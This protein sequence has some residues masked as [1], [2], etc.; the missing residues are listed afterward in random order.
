MDRMRSAQVDTLYRNVTISVFVSAFAAVVLGVSLAVLGSAPIERCVAWSAFICACATL[1][2]G[3]GWLRGR[4]EAAGEAWRLWGRAFAV[5]ALAEGV[6]WG[7][8][9]IG[10]AA[11]DRYDF[12]LIAMLCSYAMAGGVVSVFSSHALSFWCFFL[13]CTVPFAADSLMHGGGE[14]LVGGCLATVYVFGMGAIG[15]R[16][17]AEYNYGLRLRFDIDALARELRHQK[18]LAEEAN[19][20][21]S[22][23]LA[24][25]SHDLRQ[26]VHA[27]GLSVGALKA[28]SMPAAASELVDHIEQSVEALDGLFTALL[29]VSRLDAGVIT[30]EPRAFA[31]QPVLE[32]VYHGHALEAAAK[33]VALRV[34]PTSLHVHTDPVL[35]ERVLRNLVSNAVRYTDR[36]RVLVGVRR[37]NPVRVEVWDTGRGIPAALQ[38][39]VFQEFYQVDNQQRDRKAGLGLGLAIVRRLT[40]L[41][42]VELSLRSVEGQGSVFSLAVARADPARPPPGPT[43]DWAVT[44]EPANGRFILVI[45]D[46][47]AIQAGMRALLTGWGYTVMAAGSGAEML[48]LLAFCPVPPDLLICDYRLRDGENGIETVLRLQSEYNDELPAILVTGDTAPERLLEAQASGLLLL[49]KPVEHTRLRHAI[50]EQLAL[51]QCGGFP[52]CAAAAWVRLTTPMMRKMALTCAL[53]VFSATPRAAAISLLAWPSL[54]L[55]RISICRCVSLAGAVGSNSPR[56]AGGM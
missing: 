22:R 51:V 11:P 20:A 50:G 52:R 32:R 28:L 19:L 5:V 54:S 33:G 49:H 39:A 35:F 13:P 43:P 44:V 12:Q 26:P 4:S 21:K 45:D 40:A 29:D 53:T 15:M 24:S 38:E 30:P 9:A 16:T 55:S 17:H 42:G 18:E 36:G 46:E 25:A 48:E 7:W 41:L 14:R 1:H 56:I 27:L 3:M 31:V 10:L 8:A 6:A 23:F 37:G 2:V 47:P 34:V